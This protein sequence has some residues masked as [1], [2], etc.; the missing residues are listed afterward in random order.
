MKP[1]DVVV[2]VPSHDGEY[3]AQ[4]STG[5]ILSIES[6]RVLLDTLTGDK[7][8]V[9]KD[10]VASLDDAAAIVKLVKKINDMALEFQR[11][12]YL[13]EIHLS[14]EEHEWLKED[15]KKP[16]YHIG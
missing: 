9:K 13:T 15:I 3:N 6:D 1:N 7:R 4:P 8:Y 12:L 14:F 5:R 2:Y 11:L 10:Y 16:K